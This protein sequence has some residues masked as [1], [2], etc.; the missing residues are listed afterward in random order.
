[1]K[2]HSFI[3]V[4]QIYLPDFYRLMERK[5]EFSSQ[6]PSLSSPP[7]P[8]HQFPVSADFEDP[9]RFVELNYVPGGPNT[10]PIEVNNK[11]ML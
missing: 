9:F 7:P 6:H 2:T 3:F 10:D 4:F 5:S 1:M 8:L 11:L